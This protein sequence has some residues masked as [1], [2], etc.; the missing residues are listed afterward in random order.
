LSSCLSAAAVV[1]DTLVG[2]MRAAVAVVL[3]VL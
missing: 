3:V 1:A 2:Q